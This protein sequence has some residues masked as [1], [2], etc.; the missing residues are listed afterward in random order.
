M[1]ITHF[2][3]FQSKFG[4]VKKFS[5]TK[6]VIKSLDEAKNVACWSAGTAYKGLRGADNIVQVNCLVIDLDNDSKKQGQMVDLSDAL[7]WLEDSG[8]SGFIH[9]TKRHTVDEPR[10]R[11]IV[12][13]SKPIYKSQVKWETLRLIEH[14]GLKDYETMI[15][16]KSYEVAQ[17][18]L[19]PCHL[20]GAE[21]FQKYFKGEAW[22]PKPYQFEKAFSGVDL[23]NLNMKDLLEKRDLEIGAEGDEWTR[24]ECPWH[25]HEDSEFSAAYK[26][27]EGEWPQIKCHAEKCEGRGLPQF[28]ELF[29]PEKLGRKKFNETDYRLVNSHGNPYPVYENFKVFLKRIGVEIYTDE[30][31]KEPLF[32]KDGKVEFHSNYHDEFLINEAIKDGMNIR[33]AIKGLL[34]AEQS[35]NRKNRICEWIESKEW[36][37]EQTPI[38]DLFDTITF[39]S[40]ISKIQKDFYRVIFRKWITSIVAC[41][42]EKRPFTKGV[43]VFQGPQS[44]GKTSWI[45]RLL[46]PDL[47]EYVRCGVTLDAQNKDSYKLAI[48]CLICELGELDA[49]FRK[50]DISRMKSFITQT[51][52]IIRTPYATRADRYERRT[53][54]CASVNPKVFLNDDTGNSRWWTFPVESLDIFHKVDMQQV[55]AEAYWHYTQFDKDSEVKSYLLTQKEDAQLRR[56]LTEFENLLPFEEELQDLFNWEEEPDYKATTTEIAGYILQEGATPTGRDIRAISK[57]LQKFGF[58]NKP[59][60]DENNQTKRFYNVPPIKFWNSH[61][62][63]KRRDRKIQ[64]A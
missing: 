24:I 28:L 26:H 62:R 12:P 8:L 40:S 38:D 45:R 19:Y 10:F 35:R 34:S 50:T 33:S 54:F 58:K 53:I 32:K 41:Q 20:E 47:E 5:P 2:N 17:L 1:I 48:S 16:Q 60:K 55:Y 61:M 46:P 37:E 15:D 23:V 57:V 49:T 31:L 7:E 22:E 27:I 59:S 29:T 39:D 13:T 63:E 9:T 6:T 43:L 18:W 52:D 56:Y 64:A 36:D 25:A 44:I 21:Y 14:L 51:E 3:S 11:I 42:Y 4:R 30:L